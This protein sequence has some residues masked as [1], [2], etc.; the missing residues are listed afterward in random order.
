MSKINSLRIIGVAC[1]TNETA[2]MQ[3]I[4]A[5]WGQAMSTGLGAQD[6]YAVYRSYQLHRGGFTVE[7]VVGRIAALQE[8]PP[9]GC[10]AVDVPAQ[11]AHSVVT[12]GSIAGVQRAWADIWAQW[13]DGGPRSFVADIEH[14]Q[15]GHDGKPQ[16]AEVLVGLRTPQQ[17]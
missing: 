9:P 6:M 17:A 12:D 13:P 5:L 2:G 1:A 15:L 16:S 3:D 14:W 11:V 4:G 7:V 8:E 10:I